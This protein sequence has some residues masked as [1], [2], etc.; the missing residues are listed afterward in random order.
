MIKIEAAIK[1][2][3]YERCPSSLTLPCHNFQAPCFLYITWNITN[4][5]VKF[6]MLASSDRM[7]WWNRIGMEPVKHSEG[8][9]VP[10]CCLKAAMLAHLFKRTL[11]QIKDAH[12]K[13]WRLWIETQVE[14]LLSKHLLL[15]GQD[16]DLVSPCC[17]CCLNLSSL[18]I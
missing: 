16:N 1:V 12:C 8:W 3:Y 17:W 18:E 2:K 4:K 7:M 15:W 9:T 6:P 13:G 10:F 14:S 5:T 11:W